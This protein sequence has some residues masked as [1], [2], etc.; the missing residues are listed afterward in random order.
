MPTDSAC[1]WFLFTDALGLL[2]DLFKNKLLQ[3]IRETRVWLWNEEEPFPQD[4]CSL[5]DLL[6]SRLGF[7][8]SWESVLPLP[9]NRMYE[10]TFLYIA[11]VWIGKPSCE[12]L[13]EIYLGTSKF[14]I[15]ASNRSVLEKLM[16]TQ[17]DSEPEGKKTTKQIRLPESIQELMCLHR[18][19]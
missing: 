17:T 2:K 15:R 10:S 9:W 14:I 6:G 5:R 4:L 1:P 19:L 7:A 18:C 8:N 3:T 12:V 11:D 13:Q 16:I